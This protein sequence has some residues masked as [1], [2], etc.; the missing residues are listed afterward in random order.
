MQTFVPEGSDLS[1]NF[2]R[3]DYRRLGKQRV[4]TWQILNTLTGV[5]SG[6]S[7]HPAVR[8]WAGYEMGLALY[9]QKCCEEWVRRGYKDTMLIRFQTVL[10]GVVA[11]PLPPWIDRPDV[12]E[13]HRSNLIRKDQEFYQPFWPGTTYD[14][15]YVWPTSS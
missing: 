15:P 5:S 3:L 2:Q 4:E 11:S 13:S 10:D 9:G 7:N 1:L 14:L 8:M 12:T 6:W